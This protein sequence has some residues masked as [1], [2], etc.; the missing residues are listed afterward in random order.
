MSNQFL[1]CAIACNGNSRSSQTHHT[2]ACSLATSK[3]LHPLEEGFKNLT[4]FHLPFLS[5]P[6][7]QV[8]CQRHALLMVEMPSSS[9]SSSLQ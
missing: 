6:S 4:L 2:P 1:Q 5:P 9:V 8:Q 3:P 7:G